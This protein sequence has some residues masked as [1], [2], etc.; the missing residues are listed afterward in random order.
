[1]RYYRNRDP[2]P[3]TITGDFRLSAGGAFVVSSNYDIACAAFYKKYKQSCEISF[4]SELGASKIFHLTGLGSHY[5]RF[6]GQ[7]LANYYTGHSWSG[8]LTLLPR[9]NGIYFD[10]SIGSDKLQLILE[11]LNKLP[12]SQIRK[13]NLTFEAGYSDQQKGIIF[14][15]NIMKQKGYENI[16][17]DATSSQ[18]PQIAS[19]Y[20]SMINRYEA[21]V[22]ASGNIR[23]KHSMLSI[24]PDIRYFRYKEEYRDPH[25]SLLINALSYSACCKAIF[26]IKERIL[27]KAS[28]TYTFSNR[29]GK[30]RCAIYPSAEELTGFTDILKNG[31]ETLN[32]SNQEIKTEIG[33]DLL[34]CKNRYAI[35]FEAQYNHTV[36]YGNDV[37]FAASFKF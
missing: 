11:D 1:M 33:A 35:G 27:L 25:K 18:Y 15:S 12:M 26:E 24:T 37:V 7:G 17:G 22:R 16:F 10:F 19:L 31:F 21:G 36:F 5:N 4:L 14:Y 20:M 23:L 6:A 34:I 2:R 9:M 8:S 30:N 32:S 3:R 28:A 13:L 29:V